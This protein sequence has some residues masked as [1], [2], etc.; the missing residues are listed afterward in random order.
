M[1]ELYLNNIL[2]QAL[3]VAMRLTVYQEIVQSP[4]FVAQM[5][6]ALR[7][8]IDVTKKPIAK[9]FLMKLGVI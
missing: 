9:I 3:M 2:L 8:F 6:N 4:S 1:F 5:V 7:D